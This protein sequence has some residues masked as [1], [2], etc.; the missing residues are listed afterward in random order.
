MS[1]QEN[2]AVVKRLCAAF[3]QPDPQAAIEII[4]TCVDPDVDYHPVRKFPDTRPVHGREDWARW[5]Q[6]YRAAWASYELVAN[7]LIPV[8]DDGV[9]VCATLRAQGIGSGVTL[10]GE[11]FQ[12]F[13]LR[14]GRCHRVEDHLTL[15]G[16]L[17][18]LGLD[19]ETL[20]A[21]GLRG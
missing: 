17:H 21:A 9:L 4:T 15:K 20:E 11:L 12:C 14:D 7:E 5:Y 2:V 19:A 1:P 3:A 16:A 6:Q 18:A 8:G 13:W 10:E